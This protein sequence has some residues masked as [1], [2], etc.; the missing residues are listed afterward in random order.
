MSAG[1][2][3][4]NPEDRLSEAELQEAG[5]LIEAQTR[6][7]IP[8][9]G[10]V[11]ADDGTVKVAIIRPCISKGKRLRGLAPIYT[12]GMLAE[13]AAVFGSWL[14]YMD[15][16]TEGMANA[17][18]R[19]GRSISELGGRLVESYFDPE[20]RLPDD[21]DFGYRPGAVIG[22]AIPQPLVE[23][24]IKADP[25]ILQVSINAFPKGARRGQVPWNPSETGMIVEGIRAMPQ[26]SVDW[27]P[28]G[29]AGGRVLPEVAEQA[30]SL[31]ESYYDAC[32]E[33]DPHVNEG[34][35]VPQLN[36]YKTIEELREGLQTENPALAEALTGLRS[37]P[38]ETLTESA[39]SSLL[40]TKLAEAEARHA[41][42]LEAV[43]EAAEEE[44]DNRLSESRAHER[45]E[46]VALAKIRKAGL[47][48]TWTAD[49]E[50]GYSI[51]ARGVPAKLRV[52]ESDGKSA[53]EIL[54]ARI[55]ADVKHAFD[56]LREGDSGPRV[57]GLGPAR[58]G[59]AS[60]GGDLFDDFMSES[61]GKDK[62]SEEDMTTWIQE[63]VA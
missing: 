11:I 52:Q 63:G 4:V 30:V 41:A 47:P 2:D 20:F 35:A 5:P 27:V 53:V 25:E 37:A 15:H 50:S 32:D 39:V 56:L 38:V 54:E 34:A 28:R 18:R 45:L 24:M 46:R 9:R 13:N 6:V 42:E 22:R 19:R 55:D 8:K 26:G 16:L 44:I 14:M 10:K 59:G 1:D 3:P 17:V 43:R 33:R 7:L 58:S 23:S 49:L 57:S 51:G 48:P 12:P 40:D 36:E 60:T 61:L 21:D 31:I 29:G 62:L